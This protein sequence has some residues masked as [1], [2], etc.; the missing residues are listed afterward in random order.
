MGRVPHPPAVQK[1]PPSSHRHRESAKVN[2][3]RGLTLIEV[4]V[5]FLVMSV[6]VYILSSTVTASVS[7]SIVKAEKTLAVEAAMN[8]IEKIRAMPQADI[9]ALHNSDPSD[10]PYGPGTGPGNTFD[11]DGLERI[12]GRPSVGTILMPGTGAVLD[13]SATQ[14]EFGLPRDLDGNL[15]IESGDCSDRYIVLPLTIRIEWQSRLGPRSFEIATMLADLA[16]W[17]E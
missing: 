17:Q 15:V 4:M 16:K 6:A 14:P 13:E 3:R 2:R 8:T 12:P 9:F 1:F 7:H 11:V 10:D 5:A